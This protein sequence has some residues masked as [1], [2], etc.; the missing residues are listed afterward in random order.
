MP[1]RRIQ[2]APRAR[3]QVFRIRRRRSSEL[4]NG[5][6]CPGLPGSR[7]SR[8]RST[9]RWQGVLTVDL[10]G[11]CQGAV[12]RR[13]RKRGSCPPA[14]TLQ[15]FRAD[16]CRWP[17]TARCRSPARLS[18]P[19]L[20]HVPRPDAGPPHRPRASPTSGAAMAMAASRRSCSSCAKS[21]FVRPISR[22]GPRAPQEAGAHH[23]LLELRRAGRPGDDRAACGYCRAPIAILDP[24]AVAARAARARR[25]GGEGARPSRV[26][27][28][29]RPASS[30]P[31]ASNGRWRAS[32]RAKVALAT[33]TSSSSG[34]TC[35]PRSRFAS[36]SQARATA[37]ARR[38]RRARRSRS[39]SADSRPKSR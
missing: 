4:E 33:S 32:R 35:W 14:G 37:G 13:I 18:L 29:R 5:I 26:P 11:Q 24:D 39:P 31:R 15:L 21:N 16:P 10:C 25:R 27:M 8:S 1:A 36:G 3:F 17:P 7:C 19:A 30:R 6:A 12:V 22:R 38:A 2:P 28:L 20:R 34:S 23:P 9:A